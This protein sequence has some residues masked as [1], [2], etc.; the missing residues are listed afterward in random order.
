MHIYAQKFTYYSFT[1]LPNFLPIILFLF[2]WYIPPIIS[3]VSVIILQSRSD[4]ILLFTQQI[5]FTDCFNRCLTVSRSFCKLG[6]WAQQ[7][8]GRV[9]ALPGMHFGYTT[10][11]NYCILCFTRFSYFS[12]RLFLFYACTQELF[13]LKLWPIILKIMPA[14]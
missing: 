14:Y 12:F 4:Y 13:L 6:G 2:P 5:M 11:W 9:W 7:I 3:F 8:F 1:N 10:A